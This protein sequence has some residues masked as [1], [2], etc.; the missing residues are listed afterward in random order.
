MGLSLLFH[1]FSHQKNCVVL[2]D[3]TRQKGKT[4][5]SSFIYISPKHTR[6]RSMVASDQQTGDHQVVRI[7]QTKSVQTVSQIVNDGLK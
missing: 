6:Y 2:R 3:F 1:I 7:V 5:H 4:L